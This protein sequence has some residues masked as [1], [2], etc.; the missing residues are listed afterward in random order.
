[1]GSWHLP[2]AYGGLPFGQSVCTLGH[3]PSASGAEPSSHA[4]TLGHFPLASGAEPSSHASAY[5]AASGSPL[6]TEEMD[7]PR[8]P[9]LLG[10]RGMG[11]VSSR[12]PSRS[13]TSM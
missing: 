11:M 9:E 2:L 8:P 7:S 13:R 3:S 1:M 6:I 4:S 5:S 10:E 12:T